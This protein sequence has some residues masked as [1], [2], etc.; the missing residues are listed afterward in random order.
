MGSVEIH[1]VTPDRWDDLVA[2]FERPGPRGGTPIPGNCWCMGWREDLPLRRLRR[3][4]MRELV[5]GGK[6]PGLLAY[7]DG[8]PV[9][10]VAVAPRDE[11][12]RLRRSRLVKDDAV[13]GT[14]FAITC[15]YVDRD[16]RGDG[17]SS[18]LLEAA[19]DD[20]RGRGAT[21]VDA[22]PKADLPRHARAGGRAEENESFRGRRGAFE[23]RG[24]VRVREVGA[25]LVLRRH[26]DAG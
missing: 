5:V 7:E 23:R 21:A 19:V 18:A 26:L 4:G 20:A 16:V 14:A 8:R 10:W 6:R 3:D 13:D 25:R 9:G 11:Q 24:F 15:F 17:V 2:L 1:P 22:Y 12:E